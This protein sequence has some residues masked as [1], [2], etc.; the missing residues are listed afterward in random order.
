MEEPHTARIG[1]NCT[2]ADEIDEL[3]R[4]M[5][6]EFLKEESF[7]SESVMEISRRLDRKINEYMRLNFVH[8]R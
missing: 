1:D 2:L 4:R 5:T 3:R 6:E 8:N 7:T